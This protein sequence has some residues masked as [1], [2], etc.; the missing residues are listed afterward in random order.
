MGVTF[1]EFLP[2]RAGNFQEFTAFPAGVR[3]QESS[4]FE[5]KVPGVTSRNRG[6]LPQELGIQLRQEYSVRKEIRLVGKLFP[7]ALGKKIVMAASD[8]VF[9]DDDL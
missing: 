3:L 1:L 6:Q 8:R 9:L 7:N 2:T 4:A 5:E